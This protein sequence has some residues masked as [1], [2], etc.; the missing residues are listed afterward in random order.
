MF[1]SVR[2]V[3]LDCGAR[4]NH[5]VVY[6]LGCAVAFLLSGCGRSS[7]C[8]CKVWSRIYMQVL[9][10]QLA[11]ILICQVVGVDHGGSILDTAMPLP[12]SGCCPA[13][14]PGLELVS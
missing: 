1:D 4:Q 3:L 10:Q 13:L 7:I 5:L 14:S 2:H 12:V 11:Q 6:L 8:R 9:I